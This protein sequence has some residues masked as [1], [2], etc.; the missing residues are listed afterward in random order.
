LRA[1]DADQ[2]APRPLAYESPDAG[3]PKHPRQRISTRTGVLVD[4]HDLRTLDRACRD[5]QILAFAGGKEAEQRP[6][7]EIDD[8][9]CDLATAVESLVD[10][11]ALLP[12][13]SEVVAV[14]VLVSRSSRIWKVDIG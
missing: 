2:P 12:D 11:G 7:E 14:E 1:G 8:I 10:D 5:W 4:D 9:V 13:L 6:A 3:F